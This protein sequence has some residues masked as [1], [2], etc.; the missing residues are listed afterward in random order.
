MSFYLL[1]CF[2]VGGGTAGCVVA[3]RLSEDPQVTVLLVEAGQPNTNPSLSVPLSWQTL[4]RTAYEWRFQTQPQHHAAKDTVDQ[5][6]VVLFLS[7]CHK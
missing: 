7:N 6:C 4:D 2:A 5:V 1:I 3:S